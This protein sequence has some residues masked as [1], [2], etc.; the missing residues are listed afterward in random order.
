MDMDLFSEV[1]KKSEEYAPVFARNIA[2]GVVLC[3]V[4]VI[5]LLLASIENST[6]NTD[7]DVLVI[8]MTGVLLVVIAFG[9][10]RFVKTGIIKDSYDK[11]LGQGDYTEEKKMDNKSNDTFSGVYWLVITAI[12]LAYSFLTMDWG[13]SWIIWPVAGVLFAA[14]TTIINGV[15]KNKLGK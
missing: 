7:S 1:K 9:V 8:M 10:Y 2:I 3:I 5:P 15:R 13:R 12:Y 6:N 4:A 11:L 14:I